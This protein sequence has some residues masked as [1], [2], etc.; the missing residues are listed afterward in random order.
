MFRFTKCFGTACFYLHLQGE[1]RMFSNK[2]IVKSST[3]NNEGACNYVCWPQKSSCKKVWRRQREVLFVLIWSLLLISLS[4]WKTLIFDPSFMTPKVWLPNWC[5]ESSLTS[6]ST[7]HI[8]RYFHVSV[9]STVQGLHWSRY[10]RGFPFE[11]PQVTGLLIGWAVWC[12][13]VGSMF[14]ATSDLATR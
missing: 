2:T 11:P 3:E 12:L 8:G 5:L 7:V 14:R 6:L 1:E 10:R 9:C 4:E 13:S